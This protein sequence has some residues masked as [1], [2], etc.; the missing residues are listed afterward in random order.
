M[1]FTTKSNTGKQ[2]LAH[3]HFV[4]EPFDC[5]GVTAEDG[6]VK[7]G[8]IVPANDSTAKGVILNDVVLSENP[9]G[10]M[11]IHGT[12]YSDKLPVQPE[13]TAKAALSG[14]TFI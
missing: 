7:A 13:A 9:N 5:T 12:V 10:T 14:I 1:K 4:A 11:V 2:I 3:D 8:T 6:I